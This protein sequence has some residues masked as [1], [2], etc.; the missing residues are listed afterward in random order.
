[1][2]V[3]L[4]SVDDGFEGT[5]SAKYVLSYRFLCTLLRIC[6]ESENSSVK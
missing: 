4:R 3:A 6:S 1:M 5:Q 2:N